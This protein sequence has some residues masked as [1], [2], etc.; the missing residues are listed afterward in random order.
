[1]DLAEFFFLHLYLLSL[2]DL[3]DELLQLN[4]VIHLLLLALLLLLNQVI[5]DRGEIV[6]NLLHL[7]YLRPE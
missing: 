6:H 5:M 1:L 2:V 3:S 4:K 7:R